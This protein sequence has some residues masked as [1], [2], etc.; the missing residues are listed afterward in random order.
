MRNPWRMGIF[1]L[2]TTQALFLGCKSVETKTIEGSGAMKGSY[3]LHTDL[4]GN[5]ILPRCLEHIEAASNLK[6]QLIKEV[7]SVSNFLILTVSLTPCGLGWFL[8]DPT[9]LLKKGR[10]LIAFSLTPFHLVWP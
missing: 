9:R 2:F 6:G 1:L 8:R 5:D 3:R 4:R 10:I 7:N